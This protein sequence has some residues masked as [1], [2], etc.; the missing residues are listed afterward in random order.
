MVRDLTDLTPKQPRQ[1]L[2]NHPPLLPIPNH[3][4]GRRKLL[5]AFPQQFSKRIGVKSHRADALAGGAEPLLQALS[6][7]G[8]GS[9]TEGEG[10]DLRG[11]HATCFNQVLYAANEDERLAGSWASQQDV[12]VP[13]HAG[14]GGLLRA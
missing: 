9:P 14:R 11:L 13:G 10:R 5:G 7:L 2:Y 4:E 12:M 1:L 3:P 6:H 8:A